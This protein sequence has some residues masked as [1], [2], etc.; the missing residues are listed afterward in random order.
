[1]TILEIGTGYTSI[2][3]RMGAATEIVV[4]QLTTSMLALKQNV[5]IIDIKDPNRLP[6]SLPVEEVA[7]PSFLHSTDTSLGVMHKAK[8][9]V[10][11]IALA[12]K[13]KKLIKK[14][15]GHVILHFHNQYN[16]Y[17]FLKLTSKKLLK[18]VTIGYTV[19]SYVWHGNWEDIKDTVKKRYFQEIYCCQ[20]ADAVFTLN[21]VITDMLTEHCNVDPNK[22][23]NV[24]NGI[25]TNV[26]CPL[27]DKQKH[28]AF[29]HFNINPGTKVILQVGSV[30]D[31]KNQLDTLRKIAP[32]LQRSSD[33]MFCYAG[34]VIDEAYLQSINS[35]ASR[36]NVAEQVRYMGELKPGEEL[37]MLYGIAKATIM[38]SKSEAWGLVVIESLAA[39]T[40]TFVNHAIMQSQP[41]FSNHENEGILTIGED[42]ATQL[43]S[44][45]GNHE[46]HTELAVKGREMI[47]D[48]FS[49]DIAAKQYLQVLSKQ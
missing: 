1:M 15:E 30:C 25:N 21:P 20:H 36:L 17:F 48:N 11:S 14:T 5:K 40:P 12:R 19:H 42:F 18:N 41:C 39:G 3:A 2:P 16:L 37:N 4:E 43:E 49:W 38:N 34:G 22:V 8:R 46:L 29:S 6:T 44:I 24:I 10:Y 31:R 32:L 7:V 28:E 27:D 13:L 26:Y 33:T 45:I 47:K 23:H 35:E 9:V